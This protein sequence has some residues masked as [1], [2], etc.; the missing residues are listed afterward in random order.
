MENYDEYQYL[1]DIDIEEDRRSFKNDST[2]RWS[3]N[4]R[5]YLAE[6]G[7][8]VPNH[9]EAKLLRKIMSDTGLTEKEIRE[10]KKY[11][12]MLSD[13][14][15]VIPSKLTDKENSKKRLMKRITKELKL[16]KEHPLV[17]AEFKKEWGDRDK[18]YT[19]YGKLI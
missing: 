12:K 2:S 6:P 16:A 17:I 7:V 4:K 18:Y 1:D 8:H 13:I 3:R 15:K 9:N 5:K 11:R 10:H 19:S 14:Q